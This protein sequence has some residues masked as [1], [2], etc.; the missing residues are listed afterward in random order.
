MVKFNHAKHGNTNYFT[1]T[2]KLKNQHEEVYEANELSHQIEEFEQGASGYIIGGI[3][4]LT[5]KRFRYHDKRASS[6]C[7][8]RKSF[9]NSS[10]IVNTQND[11][12]YCFLC[13][14]LAHKYK[15]D[16][17]REKVSHYKKHFHEIH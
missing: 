8:L 5:V 16:D 10:S 12:N 11:D 14:I 2:N 13:P 6:S 9:C 1:L 7:N 3:K 4:N 17:H 15:V